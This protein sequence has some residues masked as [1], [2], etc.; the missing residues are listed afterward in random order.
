MN[1]ADF[2]EVETGMTNAPGAILV[3]RNRLVVRYNRKFSVMFGFVADEGVGRDASIL[4]PSPETCDA[5]GALADSLLVAGQPLRTKLH[6][7]RQDGTVFPVAI[8]A[9]PLDAE[10]LDEGTVWIVDGLAGRT[11]AQA[12]RQAGL[13]PPAA[14]TGPGDGDVVEIRKEHFP[15][16]PGGVRLSEAGDDAAALAADL[17][18][19]VPGLDAAAGLRRTGGKIG[20]YRKLLRQFLDSQSG[21]VQNLHVAMA[22]ANFQLAARLAHTLKGVAGNIG[23]MSLSRLAAEA[24][25]A[26]R[27]VPA[28]KAA[29]SCLMRLDCAL[30]AFCT[31]LAAALG[32]SDTA[33]SCA[34]ARVSAEQV[35][36]TLAAALQRSDGEV[37]DYFDAHADALRGDLSVSDFAALA[38]AVR[39]YD[40]PTAL[41]R[42]GS[43]AKGGRTAVREGGSG[44][45]EIPDLDPRPKQTVLIVDD[46]PDNVRLVANLLKECYLTRVAT[47]GERALQLAA[48]SPQ[49][50]LVLLDV[51]LPGMNG[52]EVCVRLKT[53]PLTAEIPVVFLTARSKAE[54]EEQ[55]L[56]L[57]A[58]DYIT[59]P[60]SPPILLA[61]VQTHLALRTARRFLEDKNAWLEG[62]VLRRMQELGAVQDLTILSMAL[63]AERRDNETGNHIRRT[64]H[65]VRLLALALRRH[66]R[67][68]GGFNDATIE[69][70]YKSA[71]LHDIGKVG[72]PDA[73]LKK[74]GALTADEFAVMKMHTIIGRDTLLEVEREV[75]QPSSFL[76]FARE[77]A[78]SHHEKWDGTGYPEGLCGEGIPVAARLMAVADVYDALVTRRVYK[79]AM[80]HERT[81]EIIGEGRG[82][83][84]DPDMVDVFLGIEPEIRKVAAQ[85][86]DGES[87]PAGDEG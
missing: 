42:L 19:A 71:A 1:T 27:G 82:T 70:L 62:E 84:F 74:P 52:Y 36:K 73:I 48:A 46:T 40:F 61:R 86:A 87:L 68:A 79:P 57:G 37:V 53:E 29:K 30:D 14:G 8:S 58:V 33:S 25:D 43:V 7:R 66:P 75:G 6:M 17:L 56:R 11:A 9:M 24:D 35:A 59:K 51:E 22:A 72:V 49:P 60:I 12:E 64:Q 54:E 21:V 69:L 3:A 80:S 2:K 44:V 34:D 50:D 83:H 45:S 78:C 81:L 13:M 41:A 85:L 18:F 23:A 67:F 4:F 76:R 26:I 31:A 10:N 63:I 15:A 47:D 32:K 28:G 38:I 55:G 39:N 77:I 5:L 16:L 20:F 65:Y